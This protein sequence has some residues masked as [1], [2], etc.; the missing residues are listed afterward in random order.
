MKKEKRWIIPAIVL[1]VIL[2]AVGVYAGYYFY[3]FSQLKITDI[4]FTQI[5][6]F[7]LKGFSFSGNID[8]ENPNFISVKINHIEYGVVFEPTNQLLT[9]GRIDG[10]KL[11]AKKVTSIP[12]HKT[13]NWAPA[14]SLV[15]QLVTSKEPINVAF[16]GHVFVTDNVK[17][18][19]MYKFDLRDYFEEYVAQHQEAAVESVVEKIEERYGKTIGAIA[20][21]IAGYLPDIT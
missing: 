9:A 1:L 2:L 16:T 11:S 13:V 6:N 21:Q 20:E 15:I 4:E 3:A 19:F 10:A 5:D 8:L 18:P 7:D 12:F 14:L 17:L